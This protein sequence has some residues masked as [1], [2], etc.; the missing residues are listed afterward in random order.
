MDIGWSGSILCFLGLALTL[1][2]EHR[3]GTAVTALGKLVASS[4]YLGVALALGAR[5]TGYGQAMLAGMV[6]CW[7]G[8]LLLVSR[9]SRA[10]FLLGLLAF[11]MGHLAYSTAF[12]MRGQSLAGWLPGLLAMLIFSCF[13]LRWL[14]PHLDRRMRVPVYLYVAAISTMMVLAAGTHAHRQDL[15][16]LAGAMLFVIS[17]LGVARNRFVSP[18]FLNRAV[19]LPVYFLAQLLLAGTVMR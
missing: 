6:C 14:K 1:A 4:A 9:R 12:L 7:A 10:L 11:L 5:H 13:V 2:G 17:D 8:D 16:L 3:G 18:G 15:A 19:G